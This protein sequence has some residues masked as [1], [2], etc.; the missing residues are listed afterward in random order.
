[1]K[2]NDFDFLDSVRSFWSGIPEQLK[3]LPIL[4]VLVVGG[5]DCVPGAGGAE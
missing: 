2:T 4:A 3:R 1:M 5:P